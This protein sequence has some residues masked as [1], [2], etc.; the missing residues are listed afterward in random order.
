M[1]IQ[2]IKNILITLQEKGIF[3]VLLKCTKHPITFI[4]Y[5]H[6]KCNMLLLKSSEDKFTWI[7]KYKHWGNIETVSG[8]GSTLNYT[9]NL[10]KEL[11]PLIKK[12]SIKSLFDAPCG[13]F[14]WMK[15]FLFS[16]N[17]NYIGGDIVKP[18]IDS[19][20]KKFHSNKISFIHFDL[21]KNIPP[22]T[23]MM[24]CRDCLFHLSN[25]EIKNVLQNFI[26]SKIPFLLTTTHINS[27]KLFSNSDIVTGNF[28]LLDLTSDPFNLPIEVLFSIEDWMPPEPARKMCLW[29]REQVALS[30]IS[31]KI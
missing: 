7:Y 18:L 9:M 14:N 25:N 19:L 30:L 3:F 21:T 23:D 5:I 13:D 29:S 12:Y 16:E 6:F 31:M 11:S 2:L 17:L 26:D 8:T 10:R 15:E 20:N 4:R 1:Q 22:E 24:I 28:R 27:G